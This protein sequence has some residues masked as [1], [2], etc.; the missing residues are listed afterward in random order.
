VLQRFALEGHPRTGSLQNIP[1]QKRGAHCLAS[2]EPR[3]VGD[4][5]R[6]RNACLWGGFGGDHAA[7]LGRSRRLVTGAL[8]QGACRVATATGGTRLHAGTVQRMIS[9]RPPACSTIAVQLSTQSPQL[10]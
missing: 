7:K 2:K 1:A 5:G 4:I 9:K 10:M 3:G 8:H 6:G